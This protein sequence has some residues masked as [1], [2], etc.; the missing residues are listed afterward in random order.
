[1]KLRESFDNPEIRE[2]LREMQI[3]FNAALSRSFKVNGFGIDNIKF[4]LINTEQ[5]PHGIQMNLEA[6]GEAVARNKEH[7]SRLLQKLVESAREP[8]W[9]KKIFLEMLYHE[10]NTS[11]QKTENFDTPLDS[12]SKMYYSVICAA[13]KFN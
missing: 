6:R 12:K 3:V 1:M 5:T 11:E 10:I 9:S 7:L 4:E 2:A 13:I 8:L